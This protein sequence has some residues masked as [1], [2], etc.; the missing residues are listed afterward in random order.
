MSRRTLLFPLS[1]LLTV[2]A[3]AGAV[4]IVAAGITNPVLGCAP[5]AGVD[6][7]AARQPDP[8]LTLDSGQLANA[9]IIY[10]VGA[11]LG[12]PYRAEMVAIAAAMQE[13][14]LENLP[15]GSADS[16]GLFQQRPSMGWG[17]VAQ[18]MDPVYAARAFYVRLEQ[19]PGWQSL[20]LSVVA[21]DVQH[22]G[23]PGAYGRWQEAATRLVAFFASSTGACAVMAANVVPAGASASLPRH[24][25]LPP[26]TPVAVALAIRFAIAQ[27]G[28]A[29]QFGGTCTDAHGRDMALHCDCS[30]LVQQAYRAGGVPLPRTTFAQVNV[31]T[32]VY[33]LSVLRP[34]DLLFT[35]GADGSPGNPGHV[36]MYIGDGLVVQAPQTGEDVQLN[37]VSAWAAQIVAM[38]RIA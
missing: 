1:I 19:V 8:G 21:Q 11:G 2:V 5:S 35:V 17:T 14:A 32:P 20:P 13:S 36:G 7:E 25:T 16:L 31:G 18:I 4:A 33:S 3:F 23:F 29:Y 22:S 30:S 26:G 12:L 38:R 24:F 9:W 15:Y 6:V 10:V 34:G 28:T 37:P 27:L